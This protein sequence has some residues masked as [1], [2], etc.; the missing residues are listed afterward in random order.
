MKKIIAAIAA[1]VALAASLVA[2]SGNTVEAPTQAPSQ[3]QAQPAAPTQGTVSAYGGAVTFPGGV[4]VT[5]AKPAVVPGGQY[6]YGA[7]EG[8]ITVLTITVTNGSDQPV[9]AGLMS[10]PK[11]TYGASGAAAQIASNESIG[12][13]VLSTIMPGETQT[14]KVGYGVPP[15]EVGTVRVEVMAPNIGDLPAIFKAS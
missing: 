12:S 1:S 10:V 7:V 3:A 14:A 9:N 2:C 13:S 8:K 4:K 11:V 15:A 6:A 5:V